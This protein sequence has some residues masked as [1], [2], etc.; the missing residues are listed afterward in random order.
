MAQAIVL[1]PALPA[2]FVAVEFSIWLSYAFGLGIT[3]HRGLRLWLYTCCAVVCIVALALPLQTEINCLVA[4][5]VLI[6]IAT[7]VYTK[8]RR[9][10]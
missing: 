5:L 6:P 7:L 3:P 10:H 1:L 4:L 8:R 2:L 9:S